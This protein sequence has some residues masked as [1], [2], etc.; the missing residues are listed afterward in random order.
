MPQTVH[1]AQVVNIADLRRL[2][3]RRLPRVAFDYI[4]H[5]F[6]Y[7][8]PQGALAWERII[9]AGYDQDRWLE[10][11]TRSAEGWLDTKK[12]ASGDVKG[13]DAVVLQ[14]YPRLSALVRN[15]PR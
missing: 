15:Q 8:E 14:R 7:Y 12:T 2:A 13:A 11:I 3:E 6:L 1:S 9:G 10:G 4:G 5:R